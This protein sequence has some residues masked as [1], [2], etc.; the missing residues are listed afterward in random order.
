MGEKWPYQLGIFHDIHYSVVFPKPH[1]EGKVAL[2][3]GD[4]SQYTL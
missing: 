2:S 1:Y 4:I 3:V